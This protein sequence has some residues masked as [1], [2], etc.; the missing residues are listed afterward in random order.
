MFCDK[1]FKNEFCLVTK[2]GR[3]WARK[4]RMNLQNLLC[5][6]ITRRA[7]DLHLS[8]G[9][10]PMFRVDGDLTP[11]SETPLTHDDTEPERAEWLSSSSVAKLLDCSARTVWRLRDQGALPAPI[12]LGRVIRWRRS[13]IE[14]F[15]SQLE[16]IGGGETPYGRDNKKD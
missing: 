16:A 7:S 13:A 3:C 8:S 1:G 14:L 9:A 5:L 12:R 10:P 6:C 15:L 2:I 4:T 11:L